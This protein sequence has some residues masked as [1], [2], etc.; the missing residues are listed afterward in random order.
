MRASAANHVPAP[1]RLRLRDLV[2]VRAG[3]LATRRLR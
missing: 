1:R 2:A 3:G